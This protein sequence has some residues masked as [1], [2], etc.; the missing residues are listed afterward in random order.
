RA[1]AIVREVVEGLWP[2]DRTVPQQHI[3]LIHAMA[4]ARRLDIRE[5]AETR[6]RPIRRSEQA[7][8]HTRPLDACPSLIH[9]WCQIVGIALA[10][11]S[12]QADHR[13]PTKIAVLGNLGRGV[14]GYQRLTR[15]DEVAIEV[16]LASGGLSSVSHSALLPVHRRSLAGPLA[17][18]CERVR[19]FDD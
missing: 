5:H 17:Q 4:T 15:H 2:T 7:T 9:R 16:P 11:F 13:I 3:R 1:Y 10:G 8:L 18:R 14:R 12:C 6:I 19:S